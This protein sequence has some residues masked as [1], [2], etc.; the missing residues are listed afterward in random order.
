M[1]IL[2]ILAI[3]CGVIGIIGSVMPG[4]P[5]PP[6]SWVGLLLL[7]FAGQRGACDPVTIRF[8]LIWLIITTIV[9]ILDFIVPG[10]FA[11]VT[12]GHKAASVGAIVGLFVGMFSPIGVIIGALGG[13]FI[14][15]FF[16]EEKGVWES[17]KASI[18]AFMGFICGTGIKL[19]AAG[20][21]MFYILKF[22]L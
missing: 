21:M 9:T 16:W 15:E 1:D 7:Y 12:G 4:L 17:F 14:G 18:G 22:I 3:I 11:K 10:W 5:G 19:A 13:A 8:L 2:E 6:I 20:V